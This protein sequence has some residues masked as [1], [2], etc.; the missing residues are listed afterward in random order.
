MDVDVPVGLTAD[1]HHSL[2]E[3]PESVRETYDP[4]TDPS[5]SAPLPPIDI[6]TSEATLHQHLDALLDQEGVLD[7]RGVT[8]AIKD[9]P[10]ATCLACPVS[11][12]RDYST[13]MGQLCRVGQEQERVATV[14][15]AQRHGL[16]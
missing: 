14:L 2:T 16:S 6:K 10:D 8:C 5:Y 9:K 3:L 1:W 12:A 13:P 11:S 4:L 15:I 7:E